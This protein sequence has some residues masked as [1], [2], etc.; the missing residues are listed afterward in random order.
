M[1]ILGR[2]SYHNIINYRV[3]MNKKNSKVAYLVQFMFPSNF[4]K[5]QIK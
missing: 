2:I 4:F 1:S 3:N 5:M